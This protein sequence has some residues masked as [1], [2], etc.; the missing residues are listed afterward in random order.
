VKSVLI[1]GAGMAG[2]N[3]A[4]LLQD[5]GW[6]VTVFDKGRGV[7]GRL[8]TRRIDE[9]VYDHGAQ[10]ITV[11]SPRFQAL[12]GQLQQEG[13]VYEWCRGIGT[14][15]QPHLDDGH[16]RFQGTGGMAAIAKRLARGI[17]VRSRRRV[18]QLQQEPTQ[19]TAVLESGQTASADA[20]IV[21]TPVPQALDLFDLGGTELPD[22]QRKELD[23]LKYH[24]CL[25]L[26][27]ALDQP[28]LL[29]APGALRFEEGPISFACDNQIKGISPD[30]TALTIHASSEFSRDHW[31]LGDST[32]IEFLL[33]QAQPL[34]SGTPRTATLHR[35]RFSMPVDPYPERFLH[36]PGTAPLLFAG[37]AFNGPRVE[38]AALSGMAA[39][40]ELIA[41]SI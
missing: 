26:M 6:Q 19:W 20:L 28:S 24:P 34:L 16:P 18:V 32:V 8:A 39:A 2:L 3:A 36:I 30:T 27:V 22:K 4:R 5:A 15:D 25:A 35:W 37:D 12:M 10:F 23:R 29:P 1:I 11:R 14:P 13:V 9:G 33:R 40:E 17:D 31:A 38:G 41:S 7:G 21:T